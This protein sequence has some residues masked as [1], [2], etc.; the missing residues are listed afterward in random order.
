MKL[1]LALLLSI[2]L[3]H[4]AE[5]VQRNECDPPEPP[6]VRE[7][8]REVHEPVRELNREVREREPRDDCHNQW[9]VDEF[10]KVRGK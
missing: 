2:N 10:C 8:V 5:R 9:V 7:P 6:V 4:A 3:A 1:L